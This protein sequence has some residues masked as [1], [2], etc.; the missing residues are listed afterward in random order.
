M[1]RLRP[2]THNTGAFLGPRPRLFLRLLLRAAWVRKDRALT[3]LISV[4]VVA[5]IATAALTIYS[6]L[7]GKLSR[8]FRGFGANVIIT[9]ASGPLTS[10]ELAAISKS[11]G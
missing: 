4:A 8:E 11:I 2:K 7:E 3:A 5:T 9:K 1:S 10:D 6:D